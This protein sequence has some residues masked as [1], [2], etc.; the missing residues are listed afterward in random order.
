VTHNPGNSVLAA[1]V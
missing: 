1:Q